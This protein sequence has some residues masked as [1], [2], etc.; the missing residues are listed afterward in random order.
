MLRLSEFSKDIQK[1]LAYYKKRLYTEDVGY[2]KTNTKK[3]ENDMKQR[4]RNEFY[5]QS[6]ICAEI[7]NPPVQKVRNMEKVSY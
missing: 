6:M 1:R 5:I 2:R 7:V 3:G 4:A